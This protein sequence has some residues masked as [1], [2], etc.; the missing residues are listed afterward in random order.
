MGGEFRYSLTPPPYHRSGM[1]NQERCADFK[2]SMPQLGGEGDRWE[3]GVIR[4]T[5][6]HTWPKRGEVSEKREAFL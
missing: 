2:R 5:Y 3:V 6:K 4:L 1:G